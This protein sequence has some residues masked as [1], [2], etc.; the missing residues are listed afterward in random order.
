MPPTFKNGSSPMKHSHIDR[1]IK[2]PKAAPVLSLI[3]LTA[4]ALLIFSA[5]GEQALQTSSK[6]DESGDNSNSSESTGTDNP[7]GDSEAPDG[8]ASEPREFA[9]SITIETQTDLAF[10]EGV[11]SI[12]GRRATLCRQERL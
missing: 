10:L 5:C 1:T 4:I 8:S 7:A 11:A 12:G 3:A 2:V 9:G 6:G